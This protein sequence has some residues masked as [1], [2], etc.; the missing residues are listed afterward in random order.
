MQSVELASRVQR[1]RKLALDSARTL[2]DVAHALESNDAERGAVASTS[3]PLREPRPR[4]SPKSTASVSAS[5][6]CESPRR[7]ARAALAGGRS[8]RAAGQFTTTPALPRV[9]PRWVRHQLAAA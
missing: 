8:L 3:I 9:T 7:H 1:Y 4:S 5:A 6:A 2:T